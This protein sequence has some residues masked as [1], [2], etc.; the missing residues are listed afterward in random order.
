MSAASMDVNKVH[1]KADSIDA[2]L[3]S[4]LFNV[5]ATTVEQKNGKLLVPTFKKAKK[6]LTSRR[7]KMK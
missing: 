6:W 2:K 5:Q 4:L 7:L 3:N 1:Q